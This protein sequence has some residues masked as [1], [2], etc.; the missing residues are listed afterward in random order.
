MSTRAPGHSS[1]ALSNAASGCDPGSGGH[2]AS[3]S[4]CVMA[5]HRVL[6]SGADNDTALTRRRM[7]RRMQVL[8][9]DPGRQ[10]PQQCQVHRADDVTMPRDELVERAIAQCE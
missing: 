9:T 7:Q 1:T 5:L 2:G 6:E 10:A 8:G 3:V 4:S